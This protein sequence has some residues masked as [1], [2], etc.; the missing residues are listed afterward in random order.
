LKEK[1]NEK[2]GQK[3]RN[4][5]RGQKRMKKWGQKTGPTSLDLVVRG[6]PKKDHAKGRQPLGNFHRV[7]KGEEGK[8]KYKNLTGRKLSKESATITW[9]KERCPWG[10][11]KVK[12]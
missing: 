10:K 2:R 12:E 3:R 1:T 9:R 7:T 5:G 8:S 6:V 4:G 11:T